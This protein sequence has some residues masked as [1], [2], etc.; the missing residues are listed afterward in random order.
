MWNN[1]VLR[2][3]LLRYKLRNDKSARIAGLVITA[4]FLLVLYLLTG[5]YILFG[6]SQSV[7]YSV[8]QV[9]MGLQFTAFMLILPG[10]AGNIISKEREQQTLEMLLF[11]PLSS[12]EIIVG[13]LLSSLLL[14]AA[15]LLPLLPINILIWARLIAHSTHYPFIQF[16]QTYLTQFLIGYFIL[17]LSVF[18]SNLLS[19]SL[20]AILASYTTLF[21]LFCIGTG[22]LSGLVPSLVWLNP[23]V[24]FFEHSLPRKYF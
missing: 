20:Y 23:F 12:A 6:A 2:K 21:G 8:W 3:E 1:P 24:L 14:F 11:T 15:M 17:A 10:T 19:R 13:K 7:A 22:L 4:L 9:I 16:F 5:R 18:F